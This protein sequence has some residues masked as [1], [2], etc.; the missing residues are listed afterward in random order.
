MEIRIF[1]PSSSRNHPTTLVMLTRST[2]LLPTQSI[3]YSEESTR[4]T[5]LLPWYEVH[6]GPRCWISVINKSG[7]PGSDQKRYS[8]PWASLP[9]DPVATQEQSILQYGR[10]FDISNCVDMCPPSVRR[11]RAFF[12]INAL[13]WMLVYDSAGSICLL[14]S[15]EFCSQASVF[16]L[17]I[18]HVPARLE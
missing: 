2:S 11:I 15:F 8:W 7:D 17:I 1:L 10:R 12:N 6:N 18:Q 3:L 16:G 13:C 9:T 5:L 14:E 4:K